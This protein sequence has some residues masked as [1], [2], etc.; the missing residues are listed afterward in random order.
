MHSR[1]DKVPGE[2]DKER[3]GRNRN[4]F[5]GKRPRTPSPI[6]PLEGTIGSAFKRQKNEHI[7][8]FKTPTK[9][10]VQGIVA[11]TDKRVPD[12]VQETRKDIFDFCGVSKRTGYRYIEDLPDIEATSARR[13]ENDP[14]KPKTRG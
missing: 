11:Y 13:L 8:H 6:N 4:Q 12:E 5:T 1:G 3:N 14:T 10:I 7:D 2:T 9:A